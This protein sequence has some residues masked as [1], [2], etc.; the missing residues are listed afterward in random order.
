MYRDNKSHAMTI[1]CMHDVRMTHAQ[2][3]NTLNRGQRS[4][5]TRSAMSKAKIESRVIALSAKDLTNLLK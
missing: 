3:G 4:T 1:A 2:T 5:G